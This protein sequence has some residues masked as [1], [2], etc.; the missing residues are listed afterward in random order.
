MQVAALHFYP[1]RVFVVCGVCDMKVARGA[2]DFLDKPTKIVNH[3]QIFAR[4]H[5]EV[6]G[7]FDLTRMCVVGASVQSCK[8]AS[9]LGKPAQ[10][11]SRAQAL[12]YRLFFIN[13]SYS[14]YFIF[15]LAQI[16]HRACFIFF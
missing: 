3:N 10:K 16:V 5:Y 7:K 8:G 2:T 13:A 9:T 11:H 6:T 1:V 15:I 12:M 14:K 4:Y